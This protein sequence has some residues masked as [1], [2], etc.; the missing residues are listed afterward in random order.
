MNK[1]EINA[2]IQSITAE[3]KNEDRMRRAARDSFAMKAY[4]MDS[5]IAM[6]ESMASHMRMMEP[7]MLVMSIL[8]D[9]QMMLQE[10]D[11]ETARQFMNKAKWVT[12]QIMMDAR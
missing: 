9:A 6:I 11:S 7:G 8:S 2:R 10:G 5:E 4:G 3:Y 1:T 12:S